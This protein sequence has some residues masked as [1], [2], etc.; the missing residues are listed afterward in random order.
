M[1]NSNNSNW[2][3]AVGVLAGA[4]AGYWLNSDKGRR[5]RSELQDT[6]TQYG[7]QAVTYVKDQANTVGQV[8]NDYYQ[9][10]VDAVQSAKTTIAEA[11][12]SNVNAA[13]NQADAHMWAYI[14]DRVPLIRETIDP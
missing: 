4:I 3:L 13:A 10:G 2:K 9:K 8:A 11:V 1:E 6:A 14:F 7:N 5:V 12:N